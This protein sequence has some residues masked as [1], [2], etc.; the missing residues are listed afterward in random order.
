M[1]A[2]I[3]WIIAAAVSAVVLYNIIRLAVWS[4]LR[5]H[6]KDTK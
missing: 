3:F 1:E 4:A 5:S 6:A 2:I